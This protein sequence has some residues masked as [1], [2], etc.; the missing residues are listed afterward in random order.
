MADSD[1]PATVSHYEIGR[2]LGAGG[3]GVVYAGIDRRDGGRVAIKFLY[4]HLIEIDPTFSE[5]FEREAHIASLLRSPYTVKLVD[6]GIEGET[7]F[8]VMEF[9]EGKTL[10]QVISR[11]PL[12]PARAMRIARDA[13]R[14]LE[15]AEAR[16]VVHRDIKPE[17]ILIGPKDSVKVADFGIARQGEGANLTVGAA[18]VGTPGYAAP[19]QAVGRADQRSDIYSLGATL[20]AMITGHPPFTGA[21][22]EALLE[23][24]RRSPLNEVELLRMPLAAANAIRRCMEKD[25]LDRYRSASDLAGALDR[26][27]YAITSERPDGRLMSGAPATDRPGPPDATRTFGPGPPD[28]AHGD[29]ERPLGT[30]ATTATTVAEPGAAVGPSDPAPVTVVVV[31]AAAASGAVL[32]S[33]WRW[34]RRPLVIVGA[35]AVGVA[36]IVGALAVADVFGGDE[37]A[38][39]RTGTTSQGAAT[40]PATLASWTAKVCDAAL[41]F[42]DA[43]G[44]FSADINRLDLATPTAK[45]QVL[46]LYAQFASDLTR[47]RDA[48]V[49]GQLPTTQGAAEVRTVWLDALQVALDRNAMVVARVK[50]LEPATFAKTYPELITD[51]RDA[52]SQQNLRADIESLIPKFPAVQAVIETVDNT[53]GCARVAFE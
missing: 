38:K 44:R 19:E 33:R 52:F 50:A 12:E 40:L 30:P 36:G 35:V 24:H 22:P 23:A 14:A 39:E 26:A 21:T 42:G 27:V 53:P 8:L 2:R 9:A 51:Y 29:D 41:A 13:A 20:Y 34:V 17:N 47:Y 6:Y 7:P 31:A 15:E 5:R 11:G 37:Q 45:E 46:A 1:I 4:P 43:T 49:A 18:F 28:K 32:S 25:P 3:M 16:G 48:V 10:A